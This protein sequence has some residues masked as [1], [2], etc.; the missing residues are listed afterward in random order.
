MEKQYIYESNQGLD[1][2]AT[3]TDVTRFTNNLI[4]KLYKVSQPYTSHRFRD[5]DWRHLKTFVEILRNVEGV[6]EL[7]PAG[8]GPYKQSQEGAYKEYTLDITTTLGSKI[9]GFIRCHFCGSQENPWDVYDMTVN[10]YRNNNI[11]ENNMAKV[12]ISENELK[13]IV[14]ESVKKVLNE[15]G[16]TEAGQYMLGH[17]YKKYRDKEDWS[18]YPDIDDYAEKQASKSA[19]NDENSRINCSPEEWHKYRGLRD[20]FRGGE[21]DYR[22][23][24]NHP[25]LNI[26][27]R[28]VEHFKNKK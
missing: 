15:I 3:P 19:F 7:I 26:R 21:Q 4:K 9:G 2:F 27:K 13:Q 17:L 12:Q 24:N 16:D 14:A 25:G 1:K 18:K 6:E 20:A 10:F 28:G 5:N 8:T 23:H 22:F 11:K